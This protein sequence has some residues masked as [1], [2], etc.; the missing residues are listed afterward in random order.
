MLEAFS[1][2]LGLAQSR[3]LLFASVEKHAAVIILLF[4]YTF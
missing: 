2:N 1:A 4:P 3:C